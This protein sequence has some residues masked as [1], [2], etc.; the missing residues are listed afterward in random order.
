M[1][2]GA[3]IRRLYKKLLLHQ[4]GY[5]Y[6]SSLLVS[7][8][9]FLHF[10]RAQVRGGVAGLQNSRA[11]VRVFAHNNAIVLFL[12][13]AGRR[14]GAVFSEFRLAV[15]ASLTLLWLGKASELSLLS[16]CAMLQRGV[17]GR[18]IG[19]ALMRG[20]ARSRKTVPHHCKRHFENQKTASHRCKVVFG[21]RF[22]FPHRY[23]AS[24]GSAATVSSSASPSSGCG[25]FSAYQC[26]PQP[27]NEA[28][29]LLLLT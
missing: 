19:F 1:I 13:P 9:S 22:M 26:F 4:C 14:R 10:H 6:I 12:L 18:K 29:P 16:L 15:L 8:V 23:K 11:Q 20:A 27:N 28:F 17:G 21:C 25:S 5:S 7:V 24:S 3:T 2:S